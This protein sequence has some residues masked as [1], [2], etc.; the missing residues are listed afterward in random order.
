[1]RLLNRTM[2][3]VCGFAVLIAT[4][5]QG[6]KTE[7]P[8][9]DPA[10]VPSIDSIK[11]LPL[12]PIP[13]NPPPHEGATLDLSYR[14]DAPDLIVVEVLE[15]LPGR[16]I[17][18]EHLIQQDGTISL[19]FYGDVHVAGLTVTQAKAKITLHLRKILTDE[20]LG[21]VVFNDS[22]TQPGAVEPRKNGLK[23]REEQVLPED[24]ERSARA[25]AQ[26][27]RGA[28]A[29][30]T[31]RQGPPVGRPSNVEGKG[32]NPPPERD[33]HAEDEA[34]EKFERQIVNVRPEESAR[35]F[36]SVSAFNSKVYYVLGLVGS[37]G[38]LP[39]TGRETVLDALQYAG[40]LR[41]TDSP[42]VWL[43]RPARGDQP[44][45]DYK[46]DIGAIYSGDKT[47][48]LQVFAG[49]RIV[50]YGKGESPPDS[51]KGKAK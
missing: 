25:P 27:Q 38:R 32:T 49:D 36:V 7:P 40:G 24:N 29:A 13:T 14:I 31:K 15:A 20:A 47:A 30:R 50:A 44:K 41:G 2:L 8:K 4:A 5:A 43:H 48:N 1:M 19:G 12:E 33:A 6:Q 23:Q 17:T 22:P 51:E 39:V 21:L 42:Q 3:L 16:P 11:P 37:P 45:R 18:G 28:A 35:V 46:L 10:P 34:A 9:Q 26:G